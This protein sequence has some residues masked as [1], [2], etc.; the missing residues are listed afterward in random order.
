MNNK[1]FGSISYIQWYEVHICTDNTLYIISQLALQ[2]VIVICA[3]TYLSLSA[4][5]HSFQAHHNTLISV[6]MSPPHS[7]MVRD[8]SYT[9][10]QETHVWLR[11]V[12]MGVQNVKASD[13]N[14][15]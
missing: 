4:I 1:K 5:G 9:I 15:A 14:G 3:E 11:K 12:N 2:S 10:D 13:R 7:I 6:S 8:T